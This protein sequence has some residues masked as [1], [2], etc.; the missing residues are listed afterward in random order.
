MSYTYGM[1]GSPAVGGGLGGLPSRTY[2]GQIAQ[3]F[4]PPS[5]DWLP[6]NGAVYLKSAYPELAQKLPL[7]YYG[8]TTV[9]YT[10]V[11][12]IALDMACG[13][14]SGESAF[15]LT[16]NSSYT[17]V[18]YVQG[19]RITLSNFIVPSTFFLATLRYLGGG[20]WIAFVRPGN[21]S[22]TSYIS[23]D[24]ARTWAVN[25]AATSNI[26]GACGDEFGNIY[27]AC[28]NGSQSIVQKSTNNGVSW[29]TKTTVGSASIPTPN[30]ICYVGNGVLFFLYGTGFMRVSYDYG[31][32]WSAY[33]QPTLLSNGTQTAVYS[34][35]NGVMFAKAQ[36]A[37]GSGFYMLVASYDYGVTWVPTPFSNSQ[38]DGLNV[39]C[40]YGSN[41]WSVTT[42]GLGAFISTDNGR[43]FNN[44]GII[45]VL[46]SGLK[47][48][49]TT[50]DASYSYNL[51][52]EGAGGISYLGN[53]FSVPSISG[54]NQ[55]IKAR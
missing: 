34:N 17:F 37:G 8:A 2:I 13:E 20:K 22:T 33:T 16:T 49:A 55:Y 19:G 42:S 25:T 39:V 52:S 48:C 1:Q 47:Y 51:A 36:I 54:T 50:S 23:Y 4:V 9:A 27:I 12:D 44:V 7:S 41:I 24:N 53:S 21:A 10:P 6:C 3:F 40:S 35:G 30:S 45:N 29:V 15:S 38:N 5:N 14:N 28:N 11:S 32:T 26:R 46:G 31:E 43:S 18:F